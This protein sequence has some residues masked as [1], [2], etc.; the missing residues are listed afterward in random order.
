MKR[1]WTRVILSSAIAATSLG[2]MNNLYAGDVAPVV[3]QLPAAN[4]TNVPVKAVVLFSSGVGYF[5]HYGTVN[6]NGATE[7]RFKTAQINDILKSLVLQDMDGGKVSTVTYPSQDPIEKTLKSFQVDITDNPSLADLLNQLRGAK[8]T[9]TKFDGGKISGTVLG[10]E[11]KEKVS[12]DEKRPPVEV[13]VL[14][15]INGAVIHAI[16]VDDVQDFQLD[17]PGL[18]EELSKALAALAQARD[19]DK[20]PVT[21]NFHGDGE[22]HV[23]IGYVVETPIWKTSYRL[24]LPSGAQ[25]KPKLQGWA[26]VE[27]QTDNDWNGI[28]LSLVSGRPISFVQDLYQPLYIPRPV[29]QPELYASLNPQT[30]DD[31][32]AKDKTRTGF[33]MRG[34]GGGGAGEEMEA[35]K[36]PAAMPATPMQV[37]AMSLTARAATPPPMNA[38]AS[39]ASVASAGKI[40][41]LFQYTVSEPVTLPRQKSAMLPIITDDVEAEK[42]SIYN[43]S[44]LA[45]NPLNGA[46]VKNTTGKHLLQGPI[47]VL[48]GNGYAGDARIDD[49]PP[50]QQRLL[51][52]GIDLQMTVDST[53]NNQ[54]NQIQT[55]KIV[56]GVLWITRKFQ[57]SQDYVADNKSDHDK[58]LIVEHPIKPNWKLVDTQTPEE[59]T[60]TLYR[61]KGVVSPDKTS[62]LTVKEEIVQDEQMAILPGDI[63]QV[64]F[65]SRTGEFPQAV[66]EALS[67]ASGLKQAVV[68]VDRQI[69][70]TNAKIEAVTKDQQRMRENMRVVGQ[71]NAKGEYYKKLESTLQDEDTQLVKL[72]DE[73]DGL[74]K[75]RDEAQK[76]LE[77]YLNNLTVG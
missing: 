1:I 51:S 73:K 31:G 36:A 47:T 42:V 65:Y 70:E 54:Q 55:G 40:G 58:T 30:Y 32:I 56:K 76:G 60:D 23:R 52:Y 62:T 3:Q 5:E 75:K 45:K 68:D 57:S 17:D 6:G 27:N 10:V 14:N 7:L 77:D 26:I 63:G 8:L 22:R 50:G 4:Q 2:L 66:R 20:K 61:F 21:I 11:K 41:E 69:Q 15:I 39:V 74:T 46:R 13:A 29:V 44:V 48:E 12:G 64:L 28:Q 18:Q 34:A 37:D 43:A 33:G 35:G 53:K 67:K 49:V 38:A 16:G 24:I 19:Q 9:V 71:N 72:S 25:D 59:T